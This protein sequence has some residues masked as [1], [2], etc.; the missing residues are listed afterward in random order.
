MLLQDVVSLW[1]QNVGA[2]AGGESVAA[3]GA[4]TGAESGGE[5]RAECG[6]QTD[7]QCWCRIWW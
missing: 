6:A 3:C 1:M 5:S 7:A 4:K 2:E